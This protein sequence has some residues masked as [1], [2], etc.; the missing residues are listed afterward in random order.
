M[1][2]VEN[3]RSCKISK[4]LSL[5]T[6]N[7]SSK[8]PIKILIVDDDRWVTRA[9]RTVLKDVP[10]IDVVSAI[11]S[12][13][14]ALRAYAAER[15]DIVLMDINMPPGI[16]GVEATTRIL[17]EDPAAKILILTTV[18]PGPG[19]ARAIDAGALAVLHKDASETTLVTTI[20]AAVRGDEPALI[21]ALVK[22]II[23]SGDTLPEA[24]TAAPQLTQAEYQ[25]L[26]MICDGLGYE[27]IAARRSISSHTVK[28]QTRTLRQ[29][30]YAQNHAQLVLRAIQYRFIS[31]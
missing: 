9:L 3:Q 31:A 12:G 11:Q 15:P 20:K 19:L 13:E 22:D 10:E 23:I 7:M 4:V 2:A 30:L 24:P 8:A 5:T 6:D 16:S 21:K 27:D 17:R 25:T 1:P 18:A 14:E 26:R 28:V 29:K